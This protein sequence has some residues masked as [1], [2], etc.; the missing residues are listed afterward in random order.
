MCI[1]VIGIPFAIATCI[2]IGIAALIFF[3]LCILAIVGAC[4][5]VFYTIKGTYIGAIG[6]VKF[7]KDPQAR[8]QTLPTAAKTK[9]ATMLQ[10]WAG[11][12]NPTSSSEPAGYVYPWWE[13]NP[14][15]VQAPAPAHLSPTKESATPAPAS[16]IP[17]TTEDT[18]GDDETAESLSVN[19]LKEDLDEPV[20]EPGSANFIPYCK[21]CR[22]AKPRAQFPTRKITSRC[23]HQPECC[24]ACLSDSISSDFENSTWQRICCPLCNLRLQHADVKEFSTEETFGKYLRLEGSVGVEKE[25]EEEERK[26]RKE[27]VM[28]YASKATVQHA[29]HMVKTIHQ[30]APKLAA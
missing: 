30:S 21:L 10:Q 15:A 8:T 7:L 18:G 16:S 26:E 24:L 23:P 11:G 27:L 20:L 25:E 4:A 6:L 17:S 29:G 1:V 3:G 9:T 22:K 14:E 19:N 2:L 13:G 12:K 5:L 28:K